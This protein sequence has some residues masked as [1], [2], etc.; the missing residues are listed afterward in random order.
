MEAGVETRAS[1]PPLEAFM[2][3]WGAG[4]DHHRR[5]AALRCYETAAKTAKTS[6]RSAHANAVPGAGRSVIATVSDGAERHPSKNFG[7][8][9]PMD[10]SERADTPGVKHHYPD[11]ARD[12]GG[13]RVYTRSQFPREGISE[14]SARRP[15]TL[16]SFRRPNGSPS[17]WQ[18]SS[19]RS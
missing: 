9:A 12:L 5:D 15:L 19:D 14:V 13:P 11:S 6:H 4:L 7:F 10:L 8:I 1:P 3:P 17:S 16:A 18:L 2:P